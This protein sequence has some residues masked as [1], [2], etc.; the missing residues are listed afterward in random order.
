MKTGQETCLHCKYAFDTLVD[1][2]HKLDFVMFDCPNCG[3]LC[4][5]QYWKLAWHWADGQLYSAITGRYDAF[6]YP[7]DYFR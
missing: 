5:F 3:K 2:D 4:E 6:A 1:D 7:F